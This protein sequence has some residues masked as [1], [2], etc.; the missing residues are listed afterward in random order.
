MKKISLSVPLSA[1][2]LLSA[3]THLEVL[4]YDGTSETSAGY[5]Y[6]LPFTQY[7]IT[8]SRT[9]TSCNES[10]PPS[11]KVEAAITTKLVPDGE[12]VYVINPE[13]LISAF[14]TSDISVNLKDGRLVSL[15]VET[16]D[17][18][19]EFVAASAKLAGRVIALAGGIPLPATAGKKERY[20]SSLAVGKLG[21]IKS[22]TALIKTSTAQ[23]EAA[24]AELTS[25]TAL[26]AVKPTEALGKKI[27]DKTASI[28]SAQSK[29]DA[30]TKES[31]SALSW[32]KEEQTLTWPE[33]SETFA[34]SSMAPINQV[35][36][37]KWFQLDKFR[38]QE[39]FK[40]QTK[41]VGNP[42]KGFKIFLQNEGSSGNPRILGLDSSSFQNT[43]PA[44]FEPD[45]N[46]DLEVTECVSTSRPSSAKC[47][48]F[49]QL[50]NDIFKHKIDSLIAKPVTFQ[51]RK[52][53]TYGDMSSNA[54]KSDDA[55]DGLRY[56]IPAQGTLYICN[57]GE[58]C[59]ANPASSK[60][61]GKMAGP[62][63]QM[64]NVFNIPF[65]SPAFASGNI[66]VSFDE[67]GQLVSAG[68]SRKNSAA[69][70]GMTALDNVA[71]EAL[72]ISNAIRERPITELAFETR[73]ATAQKELADAKK[74]LDGSA[75][76]PILDE[77]AML[78]AQRQLLEAQSLL[79][80]NRTLELN[81]QIAILTLEGQLSTLQREQLLDPNT[82]LQEVR[83]RY[84]A[85]TEVLNARRVLIEAEAALQAA[86]EAQAVAEGLDED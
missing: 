33:N 74:A 46:K 73:L 75:T 41:K 38:E 69:L 19:G 23:I 36:L 72:K 26:F 65:D 21:L 47:N 53:G 2:L 18:T 56:R 51:L 6:M 35:T 27:R 61:I 52:N 78:N 5:A 59:A 48:N 66:S 17:K 40:V 37:E 28:A 63:A 10:K 49:A 45:S 44:L 57:F 83:D 15:N 50:S 67:T 85:E 31:A 29:L 84:Q 22:N 62:I 82:D 64:G 42:D 55:K 9:L 13:S 14:K 32:L 86:Q 7:D 24:N 11:V 12:Q 20:C 3:C 77:I 4:P 8:I 58:L 80:P 43:Y 1:A 70:S 39:A 71:S 25:L 68:V 79:G 30:R 16:D 81:E 60:P 76:Q 34:S 54:I